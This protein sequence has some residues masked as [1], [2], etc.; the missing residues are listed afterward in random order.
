[1]IEEPLYNYLCASERLTSLLTTF[2]G[3]PAI[4]QQIAPKD[5]DGDWGGMQFAR[6]VY[7]IDKTGDDER[8]ISGTLFMDV[9][10][11]DQSTPPEDIEKVLKELVDGHFFVVDGMTYAVRWESTDSFKSE[12]NNK[13]YGCTLSFSLL[14]FPVQL[15]SDPDTVALMN[16]WT[17]Q[18]FPEA[19]IINE[20]NTEQVFMPTDEK[21]AIYWSI[22]GFSKSPIE[23][24]WACTWLQSNLSMHVIAPSES[25]R[26][27]IIKTAISE[28]KEKTRVLFPD[29]KQFII[30]QLMVNFAVNPYRTGQLTVQGSFPNLRKSTKA[31]P[32]RNINH[33]PYRRGI[34]RYGK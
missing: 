12:E 34:S 5:T 20:T 18:M 17:A 2:Q 15:S 31:E 9:M 27:S 6:I 25:T 23:M 32:L 1:M 26:T 10:C 14:A 19:I 11:S 28:L 16:N 24:G 21:P 8:K 7:D 29:K 33:Q 4:F 13:V 3:I 22:Q 30:H